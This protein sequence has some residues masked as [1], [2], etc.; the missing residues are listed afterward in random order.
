MPEDN[1]TIITGHN[2]RLAPALAALKHLDELETRRQKIGNGELSRKL[3]E[4]SLGLCDQAL[5]IFRTE[6]ETWPAGWT[7]LHKAALLCELARDVDT[8]VRSV[9]LRTALE[10]AQ[11]AVLKAGEDPAPDLVRP[12]HRV[13]GEPVR[14]RSRC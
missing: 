2:D 13:R 3:L 7:A 11:G 1:R 6:N 8:E 9:H 10:L 4:E 14:G 5:R 12:R